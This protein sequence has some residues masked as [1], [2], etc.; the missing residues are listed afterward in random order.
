MPLL[1]PLVLIAIAIAVAC[2]RAPLAAGEVAAPGAHADFGTLMHYFIEIPGTRKQV[3]AKAIA[4][5]LGP[6][7]SLCFD[8][9]TLRVA[10]GWTGGFADFTTTTLAR[11]VQGVGAA[12]IVGTV[13]FATRPGPGWAGAGAAGFAD[14]RPDGIGNLPE[15]WGTYHGLFRH[16]D[17]V[18]LA[19]AVGGGEVRELPGVV[20]RDGVTVFTR[21]LD[22]SACAAPRHLLVCEV[23]GAA[24]APGGT[25]DGVALQGRVAGDGVTAVAL[26]GAPAGA[27]LR[28]EAGRVVLDLPALA[29]PARL[30]VAIAALAP[31]GRAA[32]T[33]LVKALPAPADLAAL[34]HGGPSRWPTLTTAGKRGADEGPYAVDHVALPTDNPWRTWM[35]PTALDFFPDGRAAVAMLGGDVWVASNLDEGL[36]KVGWKRFAAGLYEPLG[37]RIVD[38]VV[39]VLCRDQI[40]R[41][42][43]LDGDGEADAYECFNH[44][45]PVNPRYNDFAFDLETDRAGDFFFA[46]GG[47]GCPLTIPMHAC[48]VKV[49]KDGHGATVYAG[50]L[51]TPNGMC[52]G[53]GDVM[54]VSDNQGNWTPAS[55]INLV[56]PGGWYGFVGNPAMYGKAVPEHPA[57]PDPPLCWIP[58]P[59]DNSSGGQVWAPA[60]WGPL[61]GGLL[62][63]SYG[64]SALLAVLHETVAGQ[65]QGGVVRLPLRF[66]SGIMRGRF[67]P[68]DGQLYVCGLKGWQTNAGL[69][70]CFD[71]VRATGKPACLPTSLHVTAK[72]LAI[73]FSAALDRAAVQADNVAVEQ[74]N[75]AWTA[76]YGSPDFSVADPKRKGHDHVEVKAATLA[77]DGKTLAIE[78]AEVQPVMQMQVKLKLKAADGTPVDVEVYNTINVVPH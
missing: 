32:F 35:R 34:C 43:D 58:M 38:G 50:G 8:L 66:D 62:H 37:L 65:P 76:A 74:W 60:G 70:G 48:I 10:A 15:A 69:D 25:A 36:G 59:I 31:D 3:V 12:P 46:K 23:E 72:G 77:P 55:R 29:Q 71:R 33:A 4:I 18:V 14:P 39:H 20:E 53:P 16:G 1:R 51:R 24:A 49:P 11:V 44:D 19:Y 57:Q 42:R 2:A 52:V 64:Q 9:E 54:T 78:L 13:A 73:G 47:H 17:Q 27:A 67:D 7:A 5:R 75:Y 45:A 30:V 21:Q 61:G 26:A 6:Q 41:L 56:K 40:V 22:L 63:I 68:K 28:C